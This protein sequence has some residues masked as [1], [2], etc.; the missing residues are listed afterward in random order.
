MVLVWSLLPEADTLIGL[1]SATG[2]P[3]HARHALVLAER[4]GFRALQGQA[5]TALAEIHL[6]LRHLSE[7]DSYARH[8]IAIHRETGHRLGEARTVTVLARL[9][10]AVP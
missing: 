7:V 1:A 4:A 9:G 2:E 8:A 6:A 3:G 10:Q 5:M